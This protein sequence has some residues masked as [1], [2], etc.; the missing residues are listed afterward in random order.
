MKLNNLTRVDKCHLDFGTMLA[1]DDEKG[2]SE[3]IAMAYSD[4]EIN[5]FMTSCYCDIGAFFS[6]CPQKMVLN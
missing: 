4:S 3:S 6:S 5:K 1:P 2:D